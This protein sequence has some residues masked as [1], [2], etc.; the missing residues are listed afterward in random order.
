MMSAPFFFYLAGFVAIWR[1]KRLASL[2]LWWFG[3][4]L[5]VALFFTHATDAL[6][7][8]L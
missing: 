8:A 4:L 7:I 6:N 2:C 3:G 1:G 5:V